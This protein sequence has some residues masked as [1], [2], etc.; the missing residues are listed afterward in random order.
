M[1]LNYSLLFFDDNSLAHSLIDQIYNYPNNTRQFKDVNTFRIEIAKYVDQNRL[2]F[3]SIWGNK[4]ETYINLIQTGEKCVEMEILQATAALVNSNINVFDNDGDKF[5]IKPIIPG[6]E[7]NKE[8]N[9]YAN[10]G[11]ESVQFSSMIH[12]QDS[13]ITGL[14]G[15]VERYTVKHDVKMN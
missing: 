13:D 14:S 10:I 8:L 5:I 3:K 6:N 7:I 2:V 12:V 15:L 1:D 9:I 11:D 4:L